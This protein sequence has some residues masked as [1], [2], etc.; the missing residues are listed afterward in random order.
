MINTTLG[1]MEE[2]VLS[3]HDTA[4]ESKSETVSTVEYCLATCN[5]TAHLTGIPD[6]V[7][8]FCNKHVHRSVH[9]TIK[10][11]EAAAGVAARL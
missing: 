11:I 7:S 6:S 5:G 10:K 3:R 2:S 4:T 1:P 8:H 9:V